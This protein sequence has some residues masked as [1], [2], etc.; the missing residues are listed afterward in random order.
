MALGKAHC[1]I[2]TQNSKFQIKRGDYRNEAVMGW[3][4]GREEGWDGG[5]NGQPVQPGPV[6]FND[7]KSRKGKTKFP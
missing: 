1:N 4:E 7:K 2:G 6:M 3:M 5:R